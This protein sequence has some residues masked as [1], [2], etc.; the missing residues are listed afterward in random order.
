MQREL[1]RQTCLERAAHHYN[2]SYVEISSAKRADCP[3]WTNPCGDLT[4]LRYADLVLLWRALWSPEQLR[5]SL[6]HRRSQEGMSDSLLCSAVQS[7]VCMAWQDHWWAKGALGV[8]RTSTLEL[9]AREL[10]QRL[11]HVIQLAIVAGRPQG[12]PLGGPPLYLSHNS[13]AALLDRAMSRS[14]RLSK[15]EF[16]GN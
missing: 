12:R 2:I 8:L 3:C 10:P 9:I 6:R 1:S 5:G 15:S 14:V 7:R 16:F 11:R 13:T 4:Y